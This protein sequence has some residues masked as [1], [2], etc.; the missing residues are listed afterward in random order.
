MGRA[1]VLIITRRHHRVALQSAKFDRFRV[2]IDGVAAGAGDE[3]RH[4]RRDAEQTPL[5]LALGRLG[6]TAPGA[7][8]DHQVRHVLALMDEG[9]GGHLAVKGGL[10]GPLEALLDERKFV[11][12]IDQF[13][14]AG[15]K[16]GQ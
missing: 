3:Q 9:E 7:V 14:Q 6:L 15:L 12:F 13:A 8:A 16:M 11:D 1:L 2:L 10:V 5:E 4:H